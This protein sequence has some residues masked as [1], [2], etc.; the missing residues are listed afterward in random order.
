[1]ARHDNS[2]DKRTWEHSRYKNWR[3][4]HQEDPDYGD[5]H[6]RRPRRRRSVTGW[7]LRFLIAVAILLALIGP[8]GDYVN[9]HAKAPEGACA[10]Q[11]VVD[12]DT[13]E[14]GCPDGTELPRQVAGY[15]AP[16]LLSLG[17]GAEVQAAWMAAL[18]LRKALYSADVI[19]VQGPGAAPVAVPEPEGAPEADAVEPEPEA[20]PEADDATESEPDAGEA[21][22]AG[23]LD[24][25]TTLDLVEET[26][27]GVG[28]DEV[29][30][31]V[32]GVNVAEVMLAAG[33]ARAPDA[34]GW[35][36]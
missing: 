28:P 16:D 24:P 10:V 6:A 7:L 8:G 1:M 20:A 33:H 31:L 3:P 30:I 15:V 27:P 21:G 4:A 29:R 32:D 34:A 12:G 17:C 14:T 26:P 2:D 19:E 13:V 36:E 23:A 11:V 5:R 9:G 22:E 18:D 25:E 35:C